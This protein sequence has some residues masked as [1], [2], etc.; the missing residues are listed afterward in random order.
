MTLPYKNF[1]A[2][3][4][5]SMGGQKFTVSVNEAVVHDFIQLIEQ[6]KDNVMIVVPSELDPLLMKV[7]F[8][9]KNHKQTRLVQRYYLTIN[10]RL[11][12]SSE[13]ES[14]DA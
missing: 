13:D 8:L 12:G 6:Y 9:L 5:H 4:L 3:L 2:L 10:T 14:A 7:Q 11:M 1:E